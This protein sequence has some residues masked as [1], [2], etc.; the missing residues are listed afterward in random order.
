MAAMAG[1]L[2]VELEKVGHYRLGDPVAP[3]GAATIA[4]AWRVAWLAAA[5]SLLLALS[6]ILLR[7][8]HHVA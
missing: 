2:G 8:A 6:P 7:G 4:R 1:L 5:L 3:V